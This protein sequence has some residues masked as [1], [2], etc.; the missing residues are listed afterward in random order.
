MAGLQARRPPK[1]V[2]QPVTLGDDFVSIW[3]SCSCLIPNSALPSQ[4]TEPTAKPTA[5]SSQAEFTGT[6]TFKL[7]RE[8]HF[9]GPHFGGPHFAHFG[10]QVFDFEFQ[11]KNQRPDPVFFGYLCKDGERIQAVRGITVAGNFYEMLNKI[12]MIGNQQNWDEGRSA[13][14]PSIRFSDVAISG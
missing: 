5:Q 8:P 6:H 10:G 4:F 2:R 1:Q 14:M 11:I 13:L 9:G 7:I 3:F 12:S